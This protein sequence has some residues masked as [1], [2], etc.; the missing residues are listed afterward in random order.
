MGFKYFFS[1][2]IILKEYSMNAIEF[3]KYEQFEKKFSRIFEI[4]KMTFLT[5]SYV[6]LNICAIAIFRFVLKSLTYI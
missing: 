5:L 6:Q 4:I 2:L 1:D 3:R